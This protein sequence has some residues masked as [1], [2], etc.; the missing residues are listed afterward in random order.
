MRK[1]IFVIGIVNL[2]SGFVVNS[3]FAETGCLPL[4]HCVPE[5]LYHPVFFKDGKYYDA[6]GNDAVAKVPMRVQEYGWGAAFPTEPIVTNRWR[7]VDFE[8]AFLEVR[9]DGLLFDRGQLDAIKSK[10]REFKGRPIYVSTYVHGW[11]HN[12]DDKVI[13]DAN[14]YDSPVNAIKFNNFVARFADMTHRFF[15]LKGVIIPP[16]V[17]GIYVGWRGESMDGPLSMAT[18]GSRASVAD[19][20]GRNTSDGSL[21]W[22]LGQIADEMRDTHAD[23]RMLLFGHSLGGRMM[24]VMYLKEIVAGKDFPLGKGVLITAI[25]PAIGADCYDPVFSRKI[26]HTPRQLP[27]F[28]AMTSEDDAAVG[29]WY[30]ISRLVPIVAPAACNP[31]SG[32]TGKTIGNYDPYVTHLLKFN[33]F[34][35]LSSGKTPNP[36]PFEKDG[37]TFS[38]PLIEN[39]SE[40]ILEPKD[41]HAFWRYKYFNNET[42]CIGNK[43]YDSDDAIFYRMDFVKKA[44]FESATTVWNV[45]TDNKLI[46]MAKD[47]DERYGT[48]NGYVSTNLT[49]FLVQMTYLEKDWSA[50]VPPP[51]A[52]SSGPPADAGTSTIPLK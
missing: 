28:I 25:E 48:H 51:R 8:R 21:Y 14:R 16:V 3:V 33:Y 41:G 50:P 15:D 38:A 37:K 6:N 1:Y 27:S 26:K 20:I 49:N 4:Q 19:D 29:K 32:A 24:S 36:T 45:R 44:A 7:K 35:D 42:G 12:A 39:N 9:E 31:K 13:N 43:C 11:H 22:A 47:S 40:I 2:L 52:P 18:L 30:P 34:A 46:N 23:S 5:T 17:I 10:L